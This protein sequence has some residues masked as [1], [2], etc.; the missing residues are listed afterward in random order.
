[1]LLLLLHSVGVAERAVLLG[2]ASW[3]RRCSPRVLWNSKSSDPARPPRMLRRSLAAPLLRSSQPAALLPHQPPPPLLPTSFATPVFALRFVHRSSAP[4]MHKTP[5]LLLH[6]SLAPRALG[7]FARILAQVAVVVGSAMGRAIVQAYKEAQTSGAAQ[8]GAAK[9]VR[10]RMSV[11]EA[12]KVLDV[13]AGATIEEITEKAEA[14]SKLNEPSEEF[15]GSP[16]LQR[17]F[18]NAKTV[19]LDAAGANE[20]EAAADAAPP[21]EEQKGKQEG[22]ENRKTRPQDK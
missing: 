1:M 8:A 13:S 12:Q 15:A 9:F 4:Q 14:M 20:A 16:Y 5:P 18:D 6:R 21:A 19:L 17:K 11:D 2:G 3:W 10:K 7:P 22:G